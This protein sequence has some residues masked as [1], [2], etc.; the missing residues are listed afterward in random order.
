MEKEKEKEKKRKG[1][2]YGRTGRSDFPS[3]EK[4]TQ[5][6]FSLSDSLLKSY[7]IIIRRSTRG[8][9]EKSGGRR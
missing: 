1:S 3:D 9:G 7:S 5:T 4:F 2:K 8:E 6:L